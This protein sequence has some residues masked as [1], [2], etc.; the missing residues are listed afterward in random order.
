M[1]PLA[2]RPFRSTST[3]CLNFYPWNIN[4]MPVV[5]IFS[6]ALTLNE[7]HPFAKGSMIVFFLQ[8]VEQAMIVAS[9]VKRGIHFPPR[10]RT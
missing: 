9:K 7:N 2:K 8:S 4:Y 1:E 5:K 10:R 6:H 3:F